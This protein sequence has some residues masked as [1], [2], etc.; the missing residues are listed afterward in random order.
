MRQILDELQRC[1]HAGH[2]L[3]IE[4]DCDGC[5]ADLYVLRTRQGRMTL[6]L[7]VVGAGGERKVFEGAAYRHTSASGKRAQTRSVY[8]EDELWLALTELGPPARVAVEAIRAYLL[9]RRPD[10]QPED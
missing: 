2:M 6:A 3:P 9:A 10:P 7:E 1:V 8:M 4:V 5:R